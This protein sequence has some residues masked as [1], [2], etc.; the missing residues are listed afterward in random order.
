MQNF[1][2]KDNRHLGTRFDTVT[3]T[4]IVTTTMHSCQQKKR[5]CIAFRTKTRKKKQTL[6]FH[7]LEL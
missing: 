2:S 7:G 6:P 5:N 4:V 1:S 3:I